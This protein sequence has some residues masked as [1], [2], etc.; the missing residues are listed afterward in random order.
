MLSSSSNGVHSTQ[1]SVQDNMIQLFHVDLAVFL[2]PTPTPEY[3]L[4]N[5][6]EECE[7]CIIGAFMACPDANCNLDSKTVT[8]Y[9]QIKHPEITWCWDECWKPG[10][11][12]VQQIRNAWETGQGLLE[13][14]GGAMGGN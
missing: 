12:A 9:T 11:V 5:S 1:S 2:R 10:Y 6:E 8:L 7:Y 13:G 14:V 4:G 3:H